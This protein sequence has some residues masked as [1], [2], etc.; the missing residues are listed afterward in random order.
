M[1]GEQ[2]GTVPFSE[3]ISNIF[4]HFGRPDLF[5]LALT[6]I[7]LAILVSKRKIPEPLIVLAAALLGL[8]AYPLL[9]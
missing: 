8:I 4:A 5:K 9:H 1:P 6:L 7:T 2:N 3:T